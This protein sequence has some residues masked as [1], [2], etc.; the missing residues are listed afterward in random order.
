MAPLRVLVHGVTGRMGREVVSALCEASD[1]ELVGGV[2][3][4]PKTASLSLP[5]GLGTVPLS[6]NM[7]DLLESTSP[8]AVVDFSNAEGCMNAAVLCLERGTPFVTGSSGLSEE[9]LNRLER[10]AAERKVGVIVA[11]N[12]ALGAVL[13]MS[14]VRRVA[15]FFDYVDII[16]SHHEGKIDAPSG[17]S[18]ALA[19]AAAEGREFSS[20][21]PE[22]Q[23]LPG[24]RGGEY[25][26]VGIHSLRQPGRS[27]HHEV[28]FGATGQTLTLRHDT[29]SRDSYMPGVLRALREVVNLKGLVLGLDKILDI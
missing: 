8:E 11:P 13:L 18:L 17:T 1:M 26:G 20:N 23:T 15:P 21:H 29:L 10:K 27:A 3:K 2:S 25:R 16:E 24:T 22:K 19:R 5:K 9:D 4:S 28:I 6:S 12:F 7:E 14:L